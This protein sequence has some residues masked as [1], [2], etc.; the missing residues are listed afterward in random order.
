MLAAGESA[1]RLYPL[2]DGT[3]TGSLAVRT[4]PILQVGEGL[5]PEMIVPPGGAAA[6]GFSLD[7]PATIG[8]GLRADPDRATARLLDTAGQ[9]VGT[10][11]AQLVSLQ[12]GRYVLEAQVPPDAT[13][14]T[15][16]PALVGITKRGDG[17]PP[18]V[19]RDYLELAGMKPQGNVP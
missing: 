7:H 3:L 4:A 12:P 5:G 8:V 19:V 6:F 1:L 9:T 13:T 17:P 18:D 15:L 11:I 10:G 16:R 14:T 2:H